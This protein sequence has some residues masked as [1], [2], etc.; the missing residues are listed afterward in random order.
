MFFASLTR[1]YISGRSTELQAWFVQMGKKIDGLLASLR[2][3]GREYTVRSALG[4]KG[5]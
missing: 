1:I 3:G 5:E 4:K 2:E